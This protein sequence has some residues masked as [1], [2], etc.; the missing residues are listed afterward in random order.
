M[1]TPSVASAAAAPASELPVSLREFAGVVI[2]GKTIKG[3]HKRLKATRGAK[4][5]LLGGRV[6]AALHMSSGLIFSMH[7]DEDGDAHEA[8]LLKTLMPRTRSLVPE[9]RLYILDRHYCFLAH[10][11]ELALSPGDAFIVRRRKDS[12]FEED[13][14]I[15]AVVGVDENGRALRDSRGVLQTSQPAR[16]RPV[17]LIVLTRPGEEDVQ[18]VTNLL[19]AAKY[20]TADI[21]AAY[22]GRWTIERVFQQITEVFGLEQLIGSSPC[23]AIFQFSVCALWYNVIQVVRAHAARGG[24][25]PVAEVSGE[26]IFTD[27]RRQLAALTELT[28]V[29]MLTKVDQPER[30]LE[31]VRELLRRVIEPLWTKRWRLAKSKR[32]TKP[33]HTGPPRK[34]ASAFRLMQKAKQTKPRSPPTLAS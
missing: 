17:R 29:A 25:V 6:L 5:G 30:P 34:H 27:T 15:P 32:K 16:Q 21:L 7:A 20:P 18:V 14:A 13:A 4:G 23:A 19:D 28:D 22:L 12:R 8:G 9:P 26:Q 33:P 2:D 10:L 31:E 11:D 3:L 24:G 1:P